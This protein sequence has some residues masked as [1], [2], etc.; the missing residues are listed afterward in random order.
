MDPVLLVM[1]LIFSF[2]GCKLITLAEAC[3]GAF[4]F[5]SKVFKIDVIW[6][7]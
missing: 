3:I 2:V 4:W 7:Y 5:L 1:F 6:Y